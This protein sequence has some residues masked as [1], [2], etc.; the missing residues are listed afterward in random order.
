ME[1]TENY[2]L[3]QWVK[4]D[5]IKMDDFN[6]AFG[7]IDAAL[8][9]NANETGGKADGA[10]TSAALTNLA[11]NLGTAGHNC[12]IAVGSY[13]GTGE[14]GAANPTVI[15]C[16]FYPVLVMIYKT[17][18]DLFYHPAPLTLLRPRDKVRPD[19]ANDRVSVGT[20]V[21]VDWADSSV[22]FYH[23]TTVDFQDNVAQA[24]YC[25]VILGYDKIAEE[26][27]D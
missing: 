12:R 25:Y 1:T 16:D 2:R 19:N 5:Q 11:K 22:S 27:A 24:A 4:A 13:T 18:A 17:E 23:E 15:Q 3:P 10:A 26:A 14:F 7:K 20:Y 6:G 9:A 8:K 21:T